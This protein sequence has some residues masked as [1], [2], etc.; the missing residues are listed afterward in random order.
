MSDSGPNGGDVFDSGKYPEFTPVCN[1]QSGD[2]VEYN[3]FDFP[4]FG[5]HMFLPSGTILHR[6]YLCFIWHPV[7]EELRK[8]VINH[9]THPDDIVVS[10]LVS[11]LSGRILRTFP[12][13][14]KNAESAEAKQRKRTEA[15]QKHRKL[16][17]DDSPN[18][19]VLRKGVD[20]EGFRRRLGLWNSKNWAKMIEEAMNS[21]VNYFGSVNPGSVGWC[22]GTK[23]EER[24]KR[25][26][27]SFKCNPEYPDMEQI[28]WINEDNDLYDHC[29]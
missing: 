24:N 5:A 21:I 1:K 6:N 2:S 18:L 26:K 14:I 29:Q 15:S 19:R 3:Y 16:Q 17:Q 25:G 20:Q 12:R 4:H 7:F 11:H 23:Y 10:T 22:V 27:F 28:P 8:Y 13:R 9:P